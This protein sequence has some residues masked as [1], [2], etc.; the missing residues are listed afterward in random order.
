MIDLGAQL[1]TVRQ[2]MNDDD[3]RY[4]TLLKIK[5]IGYT[6]VQLYGDIA[7]C[8]K[9]AKDAS[10]YNLKITGILSEIEHYE[11]DFEKFIEIAKTYSIKD[12]GI[13]ASLTDENKVKEFIIRVNDMAKRICEYGF[14]FS[15]HNHAKEFIKLSDG[16]T[17]ME[18]Y[19]EGF[20]KEKVNFMPDTFWVHKGGFDVRYFLE[21]VKDRVEILHLK[22][23]KY[24]EDGQEFAEIGNG[25]LYFEGI[26]KLALENGIENFV[27][28][29]DKCEIDP[30]ESLKISYNY[31]KSLKE[32][33][34]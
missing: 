7:I 18:H 29:Q 22:D 4:E 24:T 5:E 32:M 33:Q 11:N 10:K 12:F 2:F 6:S 8:E 9:M 21:M 15:Y 30:V 27:V 13:S 26:T 20:D 1:Y 23:M 25:N 28:E 34:I 19:I 16:K 31:L 14:T 17:I 3:K